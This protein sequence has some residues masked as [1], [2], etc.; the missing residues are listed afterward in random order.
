MF[1]PGVLDAKKDFSLFAG[2]SLRYLASFDDA[3]AQGRSLKLNNSIKS[4]AGTF[5]DCLYFEKNARNYRK[6]QVYFKPGI[7]VIRYVQ[8]KAPMGSPFIK[9]QQI[10]TLVSYHIE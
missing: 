1:T 8:E 3:A 6:D 2:D 9:L 10:S 5:T 4:P 7:G